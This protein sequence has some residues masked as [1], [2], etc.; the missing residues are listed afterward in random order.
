MGLL[1]KIRQ[2]PDNQ[3]KMFSLVTAAALT[4]IIFV[5][6]LSFNG[7]SNQPKADSSKLSSVS[8]LGVIKDEFSKAFSN[9]KDITTEMNA[10]DTTTST[11]TST[12]MNIATSTE[13]STTTLDLNQ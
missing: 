8:P 3:K 7:V 13:V 9:F 5:V 10:T 12:D 2:R 11:A 1:T 6:W 4:V